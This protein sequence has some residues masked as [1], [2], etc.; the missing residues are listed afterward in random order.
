MSS[1]T[2]PRNWSD[3]RV[4][5]RR[6]SLTSDLRPQTLGSGRMRPDV[7]GPTTPVFSLPFSQHHFSRLGRKLEGEF[8]H[9]SIQWH[10]QDEFFLLLPF[11]DP[12]AFGAEQYPTVSL[13]I[14]R[15][16]P[17]RPQTVF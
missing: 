9:L 12:L 6:K 8:K 13:G 17:C 2:R 3:K 5:R 10:A 4:K 1:C 11:A 14:A 16:Q 15:S 7:R